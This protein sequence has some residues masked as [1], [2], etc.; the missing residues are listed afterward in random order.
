MGALYDLLDNPAGRF[1]LSAIL[2]LG[3]ATMV[4][5][6]CPR[7]GCVIVHVPPPASQVQGRVF[8]TDAGC[9]RYERTAAPCVGA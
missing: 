7:G 2:G 5:A 8:R 4:C 9:F 6:A 3:L 1:A